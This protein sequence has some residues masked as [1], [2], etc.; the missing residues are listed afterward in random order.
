[1]QLRSISLPVFLLLNMLIASSASAQYN[2]N[3]RTINLTN[4]NNDFSDPRLVIKKMT[5]KEISSEEIGTLKSKDIYGLDDYK[6][7]Y[8]LKAN[9]NELNNVL[10]VVDKLIAL[11]E[12]IIPLIEKGR[13]VYRSK[14]MEAI[15]V[16]P[17]LGPSVNSLANHYRSS[18]NHQ[19]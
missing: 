17:N 10:A 7:P 8:E 3:L 14:N 1:M 15:S 2:K 19:P 9:R 18:F 16:I 5:V 12:K 11:G 6:I 4:S 13:A